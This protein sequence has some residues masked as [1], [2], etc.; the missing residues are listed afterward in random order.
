MALYYKWDVKTGF[1]FALQFFMLISDDLRGVSSQSVN[2]QSEIQILNGLYVLLSSIYVSNRVL[3]IFT[4]SSI[5]VAM[6]EQLL[7]G[8]D[9][10]AGTYGDI[11]TGPH[12]YLTNK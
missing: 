11:G 10:A 5:K 9:R 3:W 4:Y 8:N 12:Q 2:A 7:K 6:A 1:T